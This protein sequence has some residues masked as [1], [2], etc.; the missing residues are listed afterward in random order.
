MMPGQPHRGKDGLAGAKSRR[1][2]LEPVQSTVLCANA[3]FGYPG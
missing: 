3:S 1:L 2:L